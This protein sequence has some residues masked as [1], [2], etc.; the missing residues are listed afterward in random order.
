M[1]PMMVTFPT[2]AVDESLLPGERANRRAMHRFQ[3]VPVD[4]QLAR[5]TEPGQALRGM[6][7]VTGLLLA[8]HG[9]HS[10]PCLS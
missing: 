7:R 6:A 8:I 5:W 2:T 3:L 10:D 1:N 4:Q 9:L